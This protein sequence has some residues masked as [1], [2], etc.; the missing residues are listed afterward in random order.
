MTF[1]IVGKMTAEEFFMYV[2]FDILLTKILSPEKTNMAAKKGMTLSRAV[3]DEKVNSMTLGGRGRGISP[4]TVDPKSMGGLLREEA[5]GFQ[6]S[7]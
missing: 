5:A 1:R 6:P 3:L 7:E 2:A 4:E